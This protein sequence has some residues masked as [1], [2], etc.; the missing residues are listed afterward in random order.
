MTSLRPTVDHQVASLPFPVHVRAV[1]LL[2]KGSLLVQIY[3]PT[4]L[5]PEIHAH[6]NTQ[7]KGKTESVVQASTAEN[8]QITSSL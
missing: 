2:S 3:A 8:F 6:L 4:R 5:L 7:T 1:S